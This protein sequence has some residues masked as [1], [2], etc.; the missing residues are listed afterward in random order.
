MNIIEAIK[1]GKKFRRPGWHW[2]EWMKRD[3]SQNDYF[4]M[5]KPEMRREL[6]VVLRA[7]DEPAAEGE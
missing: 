7:E 5:L 3:E 1:S 2:L 6:A 4:R